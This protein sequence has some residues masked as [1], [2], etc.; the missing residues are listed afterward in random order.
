MY[1]CVHTLLSYRK[2]SLKRERCLPGSPS[3]HSQKGQRTGKLRQGQS[4]F[5]IKNGG[6]FLPLTHDSKE[7]KIQKVTPTQKGVEL[8]CLPPLVRAHRQEVEAQWQLGEMVASPLS[9]G[10]GGNSLLHSQA[11]L[12]FAALSPVCQL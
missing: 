10:Y 7:T 6:H 12:A 8:T 1:V 2:G 11:E 4:V 9:R 3:H 5:S